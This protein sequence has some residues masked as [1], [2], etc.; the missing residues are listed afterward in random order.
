MD[1]ILIH[2]TYFPSIVQMVA[3]VQS[4]KIIFEICDNYQKQ[5]YRNRTYIA[6]TNGKLLLNIPIKHNKVGKRQKTQEVIIENDFPWQSQHLKS[7][8]SA[9]RTSPYFEFY[10]DYLAPLFLEPE[11]SLLAHN[12]KIFEVICDLLEIEPDFEKTTEYEISPVNVIDLR[13]L[14]NAKVNKTYP[15]EPYTQVLEKQHQFLAN[16]SVLDLLFNLGPNAV[17]YLENQK[18][19]FF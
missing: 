5:T 6:H 13:H 16:L 11:T 3:V 15:L 8:Q 1:S 10:E 7:L 19:N 2:P 14:V 17:T 4:K 18:I 12:F 9:Y